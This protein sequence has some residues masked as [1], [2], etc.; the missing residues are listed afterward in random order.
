MLESLVCHHKFFVT[1]KEFSKILINFLV[2]KKN[3]SHV[4][5]IFKNKYS[6]VSSNFVSKSF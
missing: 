1:I 2:E 3:L 6:G 4:P 5:R